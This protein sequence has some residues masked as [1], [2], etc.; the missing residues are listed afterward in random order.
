MLEPRK[1][2]CRWRSTAP[3]RPLP[4]RGTPERTGNQTPPPPSLHAATNAAR[5]RRHWTRLP[6][7]A[8]TGRRQE[9]APGPSPPW[10]RQ[11]EVPSQVLRTPSAPTSQ[12]AS[13]QQRRETAGAALRSRHAGS[14]R[15]CPPHAP[16]APRPPTA[17][18]D[19]PAPAQKTPPSRRSRTLRKPAAVRPRPATEPPAR[20]T[21]TWPASHASACAAVP[22][23]APLAIDRLPSRRSMPWSLPRSRPGAPRNEQTLAWK[24]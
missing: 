14:T 24:C 1:P 16:P 22:C 7:N 12:A 5:G 4:S 8:L 6:R 2:G 18:R 10:R 23:S 21:G 20:P 9:R 3:T 15:A 11:Q 19:A 17:P 13:C